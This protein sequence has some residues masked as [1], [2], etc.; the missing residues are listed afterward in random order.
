MRGDA[1]AGFG[2]R[3]GETDRQQC[4]H[5]APVRPYWATDALDE[6]RRA[7]WNEARGAVTQRTAPRAK[8]MARGL[9]HARY[10]LWKYADDRTM[11]TWGR[12]AWWGA[13]SGR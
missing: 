5:R 1:H 6:V 10:A 13:V 8:G 9:K 3:A 7:A 12:A 11:P 2:G 4:R